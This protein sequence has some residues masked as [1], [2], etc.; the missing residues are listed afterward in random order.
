MIPRFYSATPLA[1]PRVLLEGAEAHHLLHVRRAKV[2]EEITLFDGSGAEYL[3][4]IVACARN[5]L[6]LDLG[7]GQAVDRESHRSLTLGVAL[8]KGERQRMLVEKCVELGV[9]AL[10]PLTTERS[11]SLPADSALERLRR[12]VI[13]ASKQ[14]GRNR[15]MV[16]ESACPMAAWLTKASPGG[17]RWIAHPGG[18]PLADV[19]GH[20]CSAAAH[21]PV[22]ALI[23]PEGGWTSGELERAGQA[24]WQCVDLG[25]RILRV[26][27]AALALAAFVG[28][29]S[30]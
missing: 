19:A 28:L 8:P 12:A 9:H 2:G 17:S 6:E 23:G 21:P 20:G 15:L 14:C 13:E 22:W 24:G 26:E 1:G 30:R 16:I 11:V 18:Q 27:T 25:P 5:S 4:R 29:A 3:A 10:Q 7:A